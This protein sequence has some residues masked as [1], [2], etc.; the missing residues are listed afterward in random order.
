MQFTVFTANCVGKRSNC[1]YPKRVRVTDEASLQA[2]VAYD[3]VCAEYQG[4]YRSVDN[5]L[6]SDCL[7]M[8]LD[9]DH[10]DDPTGWI[11]PEKLMGLIP[12]VNFMMAASRHHMLPK[13]GK[14]ARPRYHVYFPIEECVSAERYSAMKAA[15]Q[16]KFSFFDGN[17]V[18]AARFIF[19]CDCES[20]V[21]NE[22]WVSIDEEIDFVDEKNPSN[23]GEAKVLVRE[24]G[25]ELKYTSAT[26]FLRF[27]GDC[28]RE[29]KQ[30]A[31]GAV[32]EFL[33]LQLQDA[34][35]EVERCQEALVA[36]GVS[37]H[38]IK[39]GGKE[40][41]KAIPDK[42]LGCIFCFYLRRHISNS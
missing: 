13:E 19:G 18:D 37:E 33:D 22:G 9:N 30:L 31:I 36:A 38:T 16:K 8:D 1:S 25:N 14:A 7:V 27:D 24:Y 12:D 35:D 3:H 5:F 15:L 39:A 11:T 4:N 28:W 2:A 42:A 34:L 6:S 40:L 21:V 26:D 32:E 10:T 41:E 20:V 17:A 23:I 29:D